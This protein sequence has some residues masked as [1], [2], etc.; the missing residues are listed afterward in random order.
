MHDSTSR[1]TRRLPSRDELRAYL[2]SFDLFQKLGRPEEGE[3]YVRQHV[4]RF[5]KTFEFLPEMAEGAE[6]LELGAAPYYMTVMLKKYLHCS[7]TPAN[8]FDDYGM[9]AGKDLEDRVSS[10]AFG[11]THTFR[12][13]TFNIERDPFPFADASFDLVLCCEIL[14]HLVMDPSHLLREM[15]RVL[16]P[17]G[18]AFFST[19]NV[20]SL[21]YLRRLAGGRNVYGAYSGYGVYGRHNRE[22]TPS[23]LADLLREHHFEPTIY[24][25]DVYPHDR[26]HRWLTRWGRL[27]GRRDN[28]FA[29][30]KAYGQAVQLYPSWLYSQPWG[31]PRVLRDAIVMG[32]GETLQLGP[33]WH[34]FE[35][36]PPGIRWTR[37]EASAFLRAPGPSHTTLKMRA[38]GG[39]RRASGEIALN[40]GPP[41]PFTIEAGEPKEISFRLPEAL[42]PDEKESLEIRFTIPQPFVPSAAGASGDDRELGVAVE[43]L[44]LSEGL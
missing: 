39:S 11:E 3:E 44:W 16:K 24:V 38:S 9:P 30:G 25:E 36:W 23:E 8:S 22:Y 29:A 42:A 32:D 10:A 6:V 35:E 1:P 40:G 13:R 31:R 19:P 17:H 34:G 14:E 28:L 26:L 18:Y 4:D 12:Y 21:D 43:R 15:H 33:G 20:L 41:Q 2:L 37:R 5:I 27:R 7:V